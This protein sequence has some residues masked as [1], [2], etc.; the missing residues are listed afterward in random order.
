MHQRSKHTLRDDG[1]D[2]A[3]RGGDTVRGGPVAGGE[4]LAGHHEGGRV[5][6]EVEEEL[7]DDV[8]T[9]Q[10]VV[11]VLQGLV[12]ETND[13]KN[14]GQDDE[15]DQLDGLAADGVDG[16]DRHPVAGDGTRTDQDQV[17]DGVLV[18]D[19]VDVL[20]AAPADSTQDDGVV[21]TKTVER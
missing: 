12:G 1:A 2:L 7:R 6:A 16:G 10:T 19:L 21:E 20:A 14:N 5:G 15:A 11:G 4:A 17:T 9:Q 18:E 13:D 8:Q 3:G